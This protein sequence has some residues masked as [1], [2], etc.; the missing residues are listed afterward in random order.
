MPNSELA[1]MAEQ[2]ITERL[3]KLNAER[4]ARITPLQA[5]DPGGINSTGASERLASL[6]KNPVVRGLAGIVAAVGAGAAIN[7]AQNSEVQAAKSAYYEP[8]KNVPFNLTKIPRAEAPKAEVIRAKRVESPLKGKGSLKSR[9]ES[10]KISISKNP[11]LE[12]SA[13]KQEH[14]ATVESVVIRP[15]FNTRDLERTN[16]HGV[17][18]L[19]DEPGAVNLAIQFFHPESGREAFLAFPLDTEV[20]RFLGYGEVA[21]AVSSNPE[22]RDLLVPDIIALMNSYRE[23]SLFIYTT[24]MG[25]SWRGALIPAIGMTNLHISPRGDYAVF[26]RMY[27]EGEALKEGFANVNLRTGEIRF[28]APVWST[29]G[30][31]TPLKEVPGSPGVFKNYGITGVGGLYKATYYP[32]GTVS[33]RQ[34]GAETGQG[35]GLTVYTDPQKGEIVAKFDNY[36]AGANF[37]KVDLIQANGPWRGRVRPD[38]SLYNATPTDVIGVTG[39]AVDP[40]LGLGVLA[41][42]KVDGNDSQPFIETFDPLDLSQPHR[43]VP[44][45]GEWPNPNPPALGNSARNVDIR[46]V[47]TT[48]YVEASLG[49]P[50]QPENNRYLSS[51]IDRGA[52][53]PWRIAPEVLILP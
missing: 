11:R 49:N 27:R 21:A 31:S 44:L 23:Q 40:N 46:K 52:F 12:G 10:A 36:G 33:L 34:F 41:T 17:A 50:A 43:L 14:A 7:S 29:F 35:Q 28:S 4:A 51:K 37:A 22:A 2:Q 19:E 13:K 39:V 42:A 24:D 30:D 8:S 47:G 16:N 38:R 45:N 32:D 6:V 48:D 9:I 53:E 15:V 25:N 18:I 3:N 20:G 26:S 1:R 5:E